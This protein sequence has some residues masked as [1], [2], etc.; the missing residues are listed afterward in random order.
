MNLNLEYGIVDL[1]ATIFGVGQKENF[2]S[3]TGAYP[4]FAGDFI[5]SLLAIHKD[6]WT[7]SNPNA[8]FPQ[9]LP[10][11]PGNNTTT[12]SFWLKMPLTG[13]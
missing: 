13:V 10:N 4:F 3:G 5:P 6:Y 8:A 2:I 12:S 7:P 9:L 11:M 1:T